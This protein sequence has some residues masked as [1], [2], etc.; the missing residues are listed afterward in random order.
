MQQYQRRKK[1]PEFKPKQARVKHSVYRVAGVGNAGVLNRDPVRLLTESFASSFESMGSGLAEQSSQN[2]DPFRSLRPSTQQ[3]Q[4]QQQADESAPEESQLLST[5]MKGYEGERYQGNGAF[6]RSFGQVAFTK[7]NLAAGILQGEGR[8]MLISSLKRAAGQSGNMLYPSSSAHQTIPGQ[9]GTVIFNR[10]DVNSAVGLVVNS[11]RSGRRVLAQL[12]S[13]AEGQ[14]L[15]GEGIETLKR[16]YPFLSDSEDKELLNRYS[17]RLKELSESD[18]S[19]EDMQAL[20][21]GIRKLTAIIS[22]KQQQRE[23]FITKLNELSAHAIQAENMF[24]QKSFVD[25]L[26]SE[27]GVSAAGVSDDSGEDED[28]P[29][30]QPADIK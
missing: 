14:P 25:T 19:L 1:R 30:E 23:Q 17:A 28:A 11:I 9:S 12:Q 26:L 2:T 4:F 27:I 13:A 20:E 6:I 7:G 3:G 22:Q 29:E 15:R 8:M 21:Y 10:Y 5:G 18:G 16:V 24:S